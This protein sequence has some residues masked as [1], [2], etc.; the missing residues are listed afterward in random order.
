M[1][2]KKK[3]PTNHMN[4]KTL[5]DDL[6]DFH[7]Q[8]RVAHGMANGEYQEFELVINETL[9]MTGKLRLIYDEFSKMPRGQINIKIDQVTAF[10]KDQFT[11]FKDLIFLFTKDVSRIGETLVYKITEEDIA[12]DRDTLIKYDTYHYDDFI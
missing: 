10:K 8:L 1:M 9:T 11:P 6:V 4:P 2:K 7:E 5:F 3:I 12:A